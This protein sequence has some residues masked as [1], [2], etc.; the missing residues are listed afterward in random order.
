MLFKRLC[1]HCL[2][3]SYTLWLDGPQAPLNLTVYS[4]E[5]DKVHMT[6]ISGFNGGPDQFF[7]ISRKTG[8]KWDYVGNLTDPGN[9]SEIYF[10]AGSP[11]PGQKN[12]FRVE[13]CNKFNC[14]AQ[15]VELNSNLKGLLYFFFFYL[16]EEHI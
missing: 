1:H 3:Q 4:D 7:V 5:K 14:T 16:L 11:T 9:G 13:S 12:S 2:I 15:Y 10:E 8:P 6:W